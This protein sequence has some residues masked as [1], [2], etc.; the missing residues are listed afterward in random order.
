MGGRTASRQGVCYFYILKKLYLN[1]EINTIHTYIFSA[2]TQQASNIVRE[3][4]NNN[5]NN[6]M[7]ANETPKEIDNDNLNT[8]CNSNKSEVNLKRKSKVDSTSLGFVP[9][10]QRISS[11]RSSALAAGKRLQDWTSILG[12]R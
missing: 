5:S 6:I 9:S 10:S 8:T 4:K 2:A 3:E 7:T 11:K 12:K 1:F